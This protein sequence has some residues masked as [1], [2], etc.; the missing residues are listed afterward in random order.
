LIFDAD[1]VRCEEIRDEQAYEG[2][3]VRLLARLDNVRINIRVEIGFGDVVTPQAKRAIYPVLLDHAAP[4]VQAYPAETVVAEKLE[5][6]ISLGITNS[7]MKDFYD[8]WV[9]LRE[10]DLDDNVLGEAIRATF[11]R[12]GTPL[13]TTL[14]IALSDEFADDSI[15]QQQWGAFVNR[16]GLSVEVALGDVVTLMRQRLWPLIQ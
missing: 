4:I 15:K 2:Q 10:F 6:M 11:E 5:A 8:M 16:S 12:R 9:L 14:P 7:R 1:S 3:R 13:P